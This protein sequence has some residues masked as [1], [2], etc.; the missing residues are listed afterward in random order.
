[1]THCVVDASVIAAAFFQEDL[2]EHARA[3]LTSDRPLLAP[4]LI[5]AETGNVIWKRYGRGEIDRTEA[6]DLV[7]DLL[8]LPLVITPSAELLAIAVQI[9]V[10]S[11]RTVYDCLYMALA[12]RSSS[13]L[14]T[15]DRRLVNALA[16]SPLAEH[17]SWLGDRP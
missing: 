5:H 7:A 13:V 16:G 1:M 10:A 9:A 17:V 2:V 11:G 12:M 8:T 14:I 6:T 15:V 3:L 4:D